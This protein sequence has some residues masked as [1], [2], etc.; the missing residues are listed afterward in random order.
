MMRS[1]LTTGICL[2]SAC[3]LAHAATNNDE[4]F[5]N[6]DTVAAEIDG[7][8]VTLGELEQKRSDNLFQAR[9]GY[10][11]AER[12]VLEDYINDYVLAKQAQ[13]EGV[14]VDQLLERHVKSTLPKDPTEEALHVYYEGLESPQPFESMRGKILDHIREVRF[15]RAK[16]AYI[17]TLV[18]KA[19]ILITLPPPRAE[20]ALDHTPL[21]GP[22]N[23][24]VTFVEFADY[25]CPYCQQVAPSLAKLESEYKGK[26]TFAYKD[27]PLAMHSHAQKA[28]EAAHCAG[29][30]GKYWE[31][32]N[33]LFM[34]KQL[35]IPALKEE[36]RKL[37]LDA[38]AFDQCLDSG[39]QADT[40]K[41]QADEAQKLG[42]QGTP[43]FFINGRMMSGAVSY[44]E[45]HKAVEQE[46]ATAAAQPKETARR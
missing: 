45:L 1:V 3:L 2:L 16:A 43:V 29:A 35:E 25:E 31:Y 26:V 24:A 5:S 14:T 20:I 37:N 21:L 36:A 27:M 30:Q 11:Q 13:K 44:E 32:H 8:K 42:I 7:T 15:E 12:K 17:Q 38:A 33:E 22:Q 19:N 28:A 6:R 23:A 41:A 9:N 4:S 18:S 46:L 39:A 34:S 10:Y 40:V